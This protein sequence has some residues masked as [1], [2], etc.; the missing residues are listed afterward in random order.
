M[1]DIFNLNIK[2][3]QL[4]VFERTYNTV[5]KRLAQDY[6]KNLLIDKTRYTMYTRLIK[7]R[8]I[9]PLYL[10]WAN[11]RSKHVYT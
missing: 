1:N 7:Y 6:V 2:K 10:V 3:Q 4:L 8:H 5:Y 9:S 11:L